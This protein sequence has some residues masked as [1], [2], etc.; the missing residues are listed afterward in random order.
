MS[1]VHTSTPGLLYMRG[2]DDHTPGGGLHL[3]RPKGPLVFDRHQIPRTM[4]EVA[5]T[6]P[7]EANRFIGFVNRPEAIHSVGVRPVTPHIRKYVD[8][9]VELPRD[10]AFDVPQMGRLQRAA[11]RLSGQRERTR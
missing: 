8:L 3:H 10:K 9:V 7:Y 5:K 1:K 11:Y 2:E 4:T 6:I